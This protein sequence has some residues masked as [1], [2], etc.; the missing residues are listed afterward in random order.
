MKMT[1]L[2]AVLVAL[3]AGGA[4]FVKKRCPEKQYRLLMKILLIPY[5]L[6]VVYLSVLQ[7][8]VNPDSPV[9]LLPGSVIFRT[10][11]WDAYSLSDLGQ[12]FQGM[13]SR[14]AF[15][16]PGLHIL[17]Q[18]ILAYMPLGFLVQEGF[19]PI[20]GKWILL[21]GAGFSLAMEM[22]QLIFRLGWFETDDLI[23][24]ILGSWLGSRMSVNKKRIMAEQA[25]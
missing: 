17:L 24:N 3:M 6:I 22:S 11:G 19:G 12:L 23:L 15:D 14:D 13:L 10:L 18:N 8:S 2:A 21:I 1:L 20:R 7:R 16:W 5:A 4:G 9:V 25:K